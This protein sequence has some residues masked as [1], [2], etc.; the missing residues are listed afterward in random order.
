[1]GNDF[2]V[3][4]GESMLKLKEVFVKTD[5]LLFY[6]RV[7]MEKEIYGLTKAFRCK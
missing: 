2:I 5:T 6:T 3:N 4:I 1:V 7:S